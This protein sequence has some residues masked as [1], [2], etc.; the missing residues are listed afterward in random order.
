MAKTI[1]WQ[2]DYWLP[3]M[4]IYLKRPAGIKPA[5]SRDVADLSLELHIPPTVLV[6]RMKELERLDTPR[7]E[8]I[9]Q[10]YAKNPRRLA[11]A[12]RLWREMKGFGAAEEF[13]EGVEVN[14]SFERDIRPLDEEPRLTT[15]ALILCL[16]LYYQLIPQTMVSQTP[17]V[18]S[19]AKLIGV[20]TRLVVEILELYQLCDPYLHR[21]S[22][23]PHPL[24]EPCQEI[25]QRFGNGETE[26]LST[27]AEE[28]KEYYR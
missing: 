6:A 8:R 15:V 17:E 23:V 1:P 7:L 12:V 14:E 9:W 2:D 27:F 11:R 3:L 28:L 24:S 20:E 25:W 5:L 19:L 18:A 26:E 22:S 10:T 13:Y 16:D 4:Q 21:S